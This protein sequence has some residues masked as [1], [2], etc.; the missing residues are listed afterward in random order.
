MILT[1]TNEKGGCGKSTLA[2]SIAWELCAKKKSVLLVDADPQGTCMHAEDAAKESGLPH[3]TVIAM[4]P[5]LSSKAA[6]TRLTQGYQHVIIDTPG[7]LGEVMRAALSVSDVALLPVGQSAADAWAILDTVDVVKKAAL[8]NP[9]LRAALLLCKKVPNTV[10]AKEAKAALLPANLPLFRSETAHRQD[11]MRC[12]D[13]GMGVAQYAP[14]SAAAM[15]L[16]A[17]VKELFAFVGK[18]S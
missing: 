16:R 5:G 15:E 3:P 7:R 18:A 8:L 1:L 10:L 13:T 14:K 12:L 11:W 2:I 9:G 17:V 6:F 4:G